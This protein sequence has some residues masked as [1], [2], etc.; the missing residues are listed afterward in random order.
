M[1]WWSKKLH[2]MLWDGNLKIA[3]EKVKDLLIQNSMQNI[4]TMTKLQWVS[5]AIY[6]IRWSPFVRSR[7]KNRTLPWDI[8]LNISKRLFASI[9]SIWH[10]PQ[11]RDRIPDQMDQC[12]RKFLQSSVINFF[13]QVGCVSSN[14]VSTSNQN[15]CWHIIDCTVSLPAAQHSGAV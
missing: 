11:S 1:L 8:Q 3:Q 15:W 12:I 14:C 6:S 2:K 7:K 4:I 5:S 10:W 13:L 9:C